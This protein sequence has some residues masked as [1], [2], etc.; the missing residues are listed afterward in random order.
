MRPVSIIGLVILAALPSFGC[1]PE[2]GSKTAADAKVA[3]AKEKIKEAAETAA[4]AAIAK[5]D[6][7]AVE[8]R[9]QLDELDAKCAVLKDKASKAAGQAKVD[10]EKKL[11]ET[12]SK[13][14]EA[15]KKLEELKNA[16]AEHWESFKDGMKKAYED[17]KKSID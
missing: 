10:L 12:K 9:K 13:H 17:V 4:K 2:G 16:G 11:E 7:Y 14:S 3:E 8:M 6:E 5:R 15:A 1:K